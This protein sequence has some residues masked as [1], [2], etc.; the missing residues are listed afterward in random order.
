MR[1]RV[2]ITK[3]K[4]VVQDKLWKD[5]KQ[6][7]VNSARGFAATKIRLDVELESRQDVAALEEWCKL[8]QVCFPK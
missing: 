1:A 6:F 2:Q 5:R 8:F 4:N 3:D 7:A